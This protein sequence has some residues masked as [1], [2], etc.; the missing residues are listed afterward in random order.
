M[1]TSSKPSITQETQ[2]V[3]IAVEEISPHGANPRKELGDLTELADSIKS[4]GVM[5]NL[6]IVPW[7]CHLTQKGAD[8]PEKQKE[9]GYTVVIGHRRLAAAKL[10]GLETV[11]CIISDMDYKTQLSTMLLENMQRSDLSVYEEANG[12]K[13]LT[14]FGINESEIA[15]L[16]GF[17]KKTIKR[18]MQLL[19]LDEAKFKEA[20]EIGIT[21]TDFDNLSEI[22]D[23][24]V[25]NAVLAKVGT[26]DYNWELSQALRKQ[27]EMKN[28]PL[29][30]EKFKTFATQIDERNDDVV[31]VMRTWISDTKFDTAKYD[32]D[33][34]YFFVIGENFIDLYA[35]RPPCD[36]NDEDDDDN[37]A[38]EE[39]KR[40]IELLKQASDTAAD[41]RKA[42][43]E[44][45]KQAKLKKHLDVVLEFFKDGISKG[46]KAPDE[47][48]RYVCT[49][50]GKHNPCKTLDKCYA[51]LCSLGYVMSSEEKALQDGTHELF[52]SEVEADESNKAKYCDTCT[53]ENCDTCD[54]NS[55]YMRKGDDENDADD[56]NAGITEQCCTCVNYGNGIKDEPCNECLEADGFPNFVVHEDCVKCFKAHPHC[57]ECCKECEDECNSA[58]RCRR[59]DS[60]E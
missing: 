39:K 22:E 14:L 5:Q 42:F 32:D 56:D 29:L 33:R 60:D 17:S 40:R 3:N 31:Y 25:R 10:A 49:W 48:D 8:R 21:L 19:D 41:L 4:M 7:V 47:W 50:N 36:D 37:A 52:V 26:N 43:I 1:K 9:M 53:Q 46:Y 30:I 59:V 13:Q 15:K 23:V 11:P 18:R 57:G 44:G 12:F 51:Y 27:K 55:D 2:I 20:T 6:T 16:T 24:T 45:L 35:G 28:K 34:T 38:E 58:Q 54:D